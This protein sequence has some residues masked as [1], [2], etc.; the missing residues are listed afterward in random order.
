[1]MNNL[2]KIFTQYQIPDSDIILDIPQFGG[3]LTK[4][5]FSAIGA[6]MFYFLIFLIVIWVAFAIYGAF[7]I[8][9]SFGTEDKIKKGWTT[10]KSV[11]LGI[12]YFLAFFA[13]I[14]VISV[15]VG[16]GA[17]WS[18]AENLQQCAARGPASGRFYFQGKVDPITGETITFSEQLSNISAPGNYP[19][20]CCENTGVESVVIGTSS[21]TG[22]CELNSRI[23]VGGSS[24]PSCNSVV[25]QPCPCCL[26]LT[27]TAGFCQ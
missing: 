13:L 23:D 26:P 16:L 6:G 3:L 21:A 5:V 27:C 22:N 24:V 12:T 14:T 9:S 19:V 25:G 2:L 20:Y 1:M 18:W 11:W 17:P 4:G 7:L 15:F 10:I 8:I